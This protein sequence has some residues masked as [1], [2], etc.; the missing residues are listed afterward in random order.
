MHIFLVFKNLSHLFHSALVSNIMF[1]YCLYLFFAGKVRAATL[2]SSSATLQ[3]PKKTS[4]KTWSTRYWW[5]LALTCS[6]TVGIIFLKDLPDPQKRYEAL[7]DANNLSGVTIHVPDIRDSHG[8][9]IP[10][11][12]YDDKIVDGTIVELEVVPKLYLYLFFF[13]H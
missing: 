5:N 10:P 6:F 1:V 7:A 8:K 3:S 4:G 9:I 12:E 2:K 11:T 13:C